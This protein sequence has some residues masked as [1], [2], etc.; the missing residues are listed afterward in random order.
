MAWWRRGDMRPILSVVWLLVGRSDLYLHYAV[1][2]QNHD[3]L[4]GTPLCWPPPFFKHL[5]LL[6]RKGLGQAGGRA[7]AH[8]PSVREVVWYPNLIGADD[9]LTTYRPWSRIGCSSTSIRHTPKAVWTG[10]RRPT[11]P[12]DW[13]FGSD[14]PAQSHLHNHPTRPTRPSRVDSVDCTA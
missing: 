10:T 5:P 1:D 11:R 4:G 6:H 12:A 14:P 13:P 7:T 2:H 3:E 9:E 8:L